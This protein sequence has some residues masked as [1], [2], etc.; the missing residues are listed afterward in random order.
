MNN[1]HL[2]RCVAAA[3]WLRIAAITLRII[4]SSVSSA[5]FF[6]FEKTQNRSKTLENI[7]DIELKEQ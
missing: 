5:F 2:E 3:Q 7:Q 6:P 1:F 4:P